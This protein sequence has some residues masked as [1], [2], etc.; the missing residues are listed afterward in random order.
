MAA[1]QSGPRMLMNSGIEM[2]DEIEEKM[3]KNYLHVKESMNGLSDREINDTLSK[4]THSGNHEVIQLGLLFGILVD[5]T[6]NSEHM[7]YKHMTSVCRDGHVLVT[8]RLHLI[9]TEKWTRLTELSHARCLWLFRQM[10]N[11]SVPGIEP[12]YHVLLRQ[13]AGGDVSPKNLTLIDRLLDILS[14]NRAWLDKQAAMNANAM[15]VYTFLRVLADH[16]DPSLSNLRMKEVTFCSSIL[17]NRWSECMVIGRDLIRLLQAVCKIPDMEPVWKLILTD[18][19]KLDP[20]FKGL[21]QIMALKT[22]KRFLVLRLT[23]EMENKLVYLTT[24]VKFGNHKRYQ[25]WFQRQYLSTPE[26]Q[27]LRNDLI[28]F[29]C[30]VIHPS[31]DMLQSEI[32]P[33]WAVIGWLLTT[34]TSNVAASTA[35]LALFWDWLFYE[36]KADNSSIMNIEPAIL[37][38]QHSMKPHLQITVSLLDF[39]VRIIP[40]FCPPLKSNVRAGIHAALADIASKK[41]LPS[42]S[43]LFDSA[44]L[45][46]ELRGHLREAFPQFCIQP[47]TP[48]EGPPQLIKKDPNKLETPLDLL[49]PPTSPVELSPAAILNYPSDRPLSPTDTA[50]TFSD[51][52]TELANANN[53]DVSP[54]V[55]KPIEVPRTRRL[56]SLTERPRE[57]LDDYMNKITGDFKTVLEQLKNES[58][59]EK[60]CELTEKLLQCID[61]TEDF[62]DPLAP[63]VASALCTM[64][65]PI[66]T[67]VSLPQEINEETL[68]DS[69]VSPLFVIFRNICS[70]PMD[71]PSRE[72]LTYFLY[73]M[74]AFEPR[75]GYLLL[76]YLKVS[77]STDEK[78][79]TYKN[80]A[81]FAAD[82]K[83]FKTFILDDLKLCQEDDMRMF[84]YLVPD[85]YNNFL[86]ATVTNPELML[87]ICS[88]ID[89]TQLLSFMCQILQGHLLM[90]RKDSILAVLNHSLEWET[91]EQYFLWQLLISHDLPAE[92]IL[93][94][95]SKLEFPKHAEAITSLLGLLK[96]KSP[97]NDMMRLVLCRRPSKFD[98][99]TTSIIKHWAHEDEDKTAESLAHFISHNLATPKKTTKARSKKEMPS[100]DNIL[101]HLDIM[102]QLCKNISFLT[103]DSIQTSLQQVQ[104]TSS[105]QQRQRFSELFALIMDDEDEEE[106]PSKRNLRQTA[107]RRANNASPKLPND[108]RRR[109]SSSSSDSEDEDLRVPAKKKKKTS[110]IELDDSD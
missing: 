50:S 51:D 71:E 109:Q 33:R 76:Y 52:E 94:I 88:T 19:A 84:T 101:T 85:V 1:L 56:S 70:L 102:R 48:T 98:L 22:P 49:M 89:G 62:D 55:F 25:D 34:C 42:L 12:V 64:F 43:A 69:I 75:V 14:E 20:S 86:S 68:E 81:H 67:S 105:E 41:V 9:T 57:T 28:R 16:L 61:E 24:K 44:R 82:E 39:L 77:K 10:V 63:A 103:N 53:T 35:K 4:Q 32:I 18:P 11:S 90:F 92:H 36:K 6:P 47:S 21:P 78:M 23:P 74:H 45:D 65:G 106:V 46:R 38:M 2:K 5:P 99:F 7:Y 31:N 79:L 58:D 107:A 100:T 59:D 15:A 95:L 54:L 40:A 29:I 72:D 73:V 26:S 110:V 96:Q 87:L 37:V 13:V 97:N 60:K 66:F 93:P 3:L 104:Q 91:I 80:M 8:S 27:S 108:R 30:A 83:D 17:M